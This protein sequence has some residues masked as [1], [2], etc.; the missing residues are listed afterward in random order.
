MNLFYKILK[1]FG[2]VNAALPSA[3]LLIFWF[4][5]MWAMRQLQP[6]R[7]TDGAWEW[8]VV[9]N[10]WFANK[11]SD[12]WAATTLGFIIFLSPGYE[13]DPVTHVHERR[14]VQQYWCLGLLFF[15]AYY[16]AMMI[17][18]ANTT[19]P[20]NIMLTNGYWWNWFEMDARRFAQNNPNH[21]LF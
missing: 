19:P 17:G 15:V 3:L 2:Y 8:G 10:S 20:P 12:M 1:S 9:P 4:L 6:K 11:Y 21:R 7:F 18:Y 13:N 5:P 14:H 16:C